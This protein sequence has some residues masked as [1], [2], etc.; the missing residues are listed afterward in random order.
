MIQLHATDGATGAARG[1]AVGAGLA[2]SP[3]DAL[4]S[5]QLLQEI[6]PEP[7]SQA[8]V[9]DAYAGWR[10]GL[11]ALLESQGVPR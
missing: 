4:R 9:A 10:Q 3:Q 5:L 1:A 2:A 11:D 8:S 7:R 6:H